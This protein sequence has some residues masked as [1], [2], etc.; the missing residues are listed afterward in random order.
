MTLSAAQATFEILLLSYLYSAHPQKSPCEQ[1]SSGIFP[2]HTETC[3][4]E[5]HWSKT[6]KT[7]HA[8]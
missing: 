4:A 1:I 8:T 7:T 3:T 5:K 2:E 6:H